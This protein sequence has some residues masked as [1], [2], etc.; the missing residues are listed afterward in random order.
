MHG[1]LSHLP[2]LCFITVSEKSDRYGEILSEK[3]D[4]WGLEKGVKAQTLILSP[5]TIPM[6]DIKIP[7][8]YIS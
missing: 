7:F 1:Q 5:K 6:W 8:H 3:L 4:R 2:G